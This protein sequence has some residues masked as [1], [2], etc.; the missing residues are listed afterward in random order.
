MTVIVL[1][2][3]LKILFWIGVV[4]VALYYLIFTEDGRAIGA[5]ILA[6]LVGIGGIILFFIAIGAGVVYVLF[7][8]LRS[9][10]GV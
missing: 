1:W 4:T 7:N 9:F 6:F 10:L 8:I 3:I 2:I 5:A